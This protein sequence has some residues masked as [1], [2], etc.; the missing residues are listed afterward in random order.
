[1]LVGVALIASGCG[2]GSSDNDKAAFIAK[3]EQVCKR[4]AAQLRLTISQRFNSGATKEQLVQFTKSVALPNIEQQ[5]QQIRALPQPS[6]DRAALNRYYSQ[7][8]QGIA[9]VK[10]NPALVIG[11]TVPPAFKRADR[12]ARAYGIGRCVR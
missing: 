12:V 9:Q 3:A 8:E 4:S 7:Y 1:V 11:T 2:G 5:L 10:R 6:E